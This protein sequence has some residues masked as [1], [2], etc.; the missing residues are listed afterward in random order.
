MNSIADVLERFN[1]KERNHLVRMALDQGDQPPKLGDHFRADVAA[2]LQFQGA[3]GADAWWATD[4]HLEW[5]AGALVVYAK[6][7]QEAK[8]ARDKFSDQLIKGNQE[9]VDLVI[10]SGLD[11][12]LIEAKGESHWNKNSL[13]AS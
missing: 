8:Q 3:I 5:L 11:L 10:A 4:Y 12:I 2:A 9:D 13:R 6:G 7:E 1:R